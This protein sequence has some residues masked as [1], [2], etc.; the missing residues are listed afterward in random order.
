M[1]KTGAILGATY[2]T[3]QTQDRNPQ[4]EEHEELVIC[5]S[6]AVIHLTVRHAMKRDIQNCSSINDSSKSFAPKDSGD[7]S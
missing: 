3:K 6:N 5:P 4:K 1:N 2:S 7:P